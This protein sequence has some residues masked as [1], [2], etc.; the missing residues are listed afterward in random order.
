LLAVDDAITDRSAATPHWVTRI[1]FLGEGL[2]GSPE[3]GMS[4]LPDADS[5][6]IWLSDPKRGRDCKGWWRKAGPG[7]TWSMLCQDGLTA[8]G[9]LT[10]PASGLGSG[11]GRDAKGRLVEFFFA[12][13]P[14]R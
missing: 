10:D 12:P 14:A 3:A 4:Y 8:E 9:E 2:A 13:D 7:S 5:G 11:T 1:Q 6:Y